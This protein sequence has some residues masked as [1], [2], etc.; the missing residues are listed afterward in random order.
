M[1]SV[2]EGFEEILARFRERESIPHCEKI[3][4]PRVEVFA[5]I[6]I[7]IWV[8]NLFDFS[9]LLKIANICAKETKDNIVVVCYVGSGHARATSSFFCEKLGFQRK[10]LIGK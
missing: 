2:A 10:E 6:L 1:P 3:V 7:D 5:K 4:T 8:S 9:L